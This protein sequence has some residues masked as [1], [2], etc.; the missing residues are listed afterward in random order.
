MEAR[1]RGARHSLGKIAPMHEASLPVIEPPAARSVTMRI[2]DQVGEMENVRVFW[3]AH[4]SHPNHDLDY[5]FLIAR[6]RKE[7]VGPLVFA[8]EADAELHATLAGRVEDTRQNFQFG[9]MSCGSVRVRKLSFVTNGALGEIS[10]EDARLLVQSVRSSLCARGL[11]FAVLHNQPVD[12]CL[13]RE[14]LSGTPAPFRDHGGRE[15]EHWRM[16]LPENFEEFLGR[17]KKKHR[18]WLNRLPRV[19]EKA[20]PG[21]VETKVFETVAEVEQFCRDADAVAALTYQRKLGAGFANIGETREYCELLAK[22]NALKGSI[23]YVDGKPCAYWLASTHCNIL[24]LHATGYDPVF[25]KYEVGTILF[26]NLMRDV[27]GT[28]LEKVDFGLGAA[29]YKERFGDE[30]WL[31]KDYYVF[32]FSVRGLMLNAVISGG[33]F[34][35]KFARWVISQAGP[36]GRFKK[37]WRRRL[38][39]T[40]STVEPEN[41]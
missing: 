10:R 3:N 36:V 23:L 38:V 19:L 14:A 1:R 31:E 39:A 27:C 34:A 35:E 28:V 6:S 20:F 41:S 40:R 22:R 17:R 25:R 8:L 37:L 18:Y 2:V 29:D 4:E 13:A 16:S 7:V 12:S 9:Y 24:F 26:L 5:F 11:D 32:A 33:M 15:R 30:N 21:M